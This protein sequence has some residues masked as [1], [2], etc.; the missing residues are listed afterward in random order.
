M[1]L[2]VYLYK[3]EDFTAG[4]TAEEEYSKRTEHLWSEPVAKDARFRSRSASNAREQAQAAVAQELGMIKG[5]WD[6]QCPR[7]KIELP[8]REYPE[9]CFK[10]GYLRSS[11]NEGGINHVLRQKGLPDLYMVF[12]PADRYRFVPDWQGAKARIGKLREAYAVTLAG[13]KGQHYVTFVGQNIFI[14]PSTLPSS[15]SAALE[16][17]GQELSKSVGYGSYSNCNGYFFLKAPLEV[18][19]AIP[20][21][22]ALGKPGVYLVCK[23]KQ[24][25]QDQKSQ[26]WYAQALEITEEMID[27]VLAQPDPEHYALHWSA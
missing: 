14:N 15:E 11:Y 6:F 12:E 19:G 10:I 1:G 21:M 20:G 22:G 9:H 18:V 2:D 25:S 3:Y 16:L 7:E 4:T 8:S 26:D 13:W 24:E 5:E 23:T 17:Y 27:Y